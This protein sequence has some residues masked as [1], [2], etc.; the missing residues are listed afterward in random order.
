[1]T[2]NFPELEAFRGGIFD[3]VMPELYTHNTFDAG[4]YR[5]E[6]MHYVYRSLLYERSVFGRSILPN[7]ELYWDG[8]SMTPDE[9]CRWLLES[10]AAGYDS[11][12]VVSE[13]KLYLEHVHPTQ[14]EYRVAY[15]AI[16]RALSKL[17]AFGLPEVRFQFVV[18]QDLE[19]A[20]YRRS[21]RQ[22]DWYV[23]ET[24][25]LFKTLDRHFGGG[26]IINDRTTDLPH[27]ELR[28]LAGANLRQYVIFPRGLACPATDTPHVKRMEIDPGQSVA[29]L[30]G[31]LDDF[32]APCADS[33]VLEKSPLIYV[34]W[35]RR[36]DG[37]RFCSVIN[38]GTAT[39]RVRIRTADA[40]WH[41]LV[42]SGPLSGKKVRIHQMRDVL[43]ID[44]DAGACAAFLVRK[45]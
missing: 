6:D 44:L 28:G 33:C 13:G 29:S 15:R 19:R 9:L 30:Q 4:G 2:Y 45:R 32:L 5:R 16:F 10:H 37:T 22:W 42:D 8:R 39:G 21:P 24:C 3:L 38:H 23:G 11:Y 25:R 12:S 26:A 34:N 40:P 14:E 17:P 36:D 18:S 1:L 35:N 20:L 7:V 41:C 31:E 43:E 27:S